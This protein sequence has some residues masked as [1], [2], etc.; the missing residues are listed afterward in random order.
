MDS[1][2]VPNAGLLRLRF[3]LNGGIVL[4]FGES[5]EDFCG[6]LLKLV[7]LLDPVQEQIYVFLVD[8]CVFRQ[9]ERDWLVTFHGLSGQGLCSE[10]CPFM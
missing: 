10:D 8:R 7:E 1:Q 3:L 5:R 4:Q 6:V 2:P 9:G